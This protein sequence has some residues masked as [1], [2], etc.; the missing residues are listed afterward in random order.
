M[1]LSQTSVIGGALVIAWIVFIVTRGELPCWLALVG[2]GPGAGNCPA[3]TATTVSTVLSTVT[4]FAGTGVGSP[5]FIGVTLGGSGGSGGIPTG[6][7]P[8]VYDP[9]GGCFLG[10]C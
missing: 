5:S 2:I 8:P 10:G 4:T 9:T 3:N 6:G 1:K 7:G